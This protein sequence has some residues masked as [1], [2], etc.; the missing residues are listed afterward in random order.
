MTRSEMISKAYKLLSDELTIVVLEDG[1]DRVECTREGT[2]VTIIIDSSRR[3][4]TK[5]GP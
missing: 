2:R 4:E 3:K 5:N 1:L